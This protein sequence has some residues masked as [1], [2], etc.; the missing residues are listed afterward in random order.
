[1]AL[2]SCSTRCLELC[3]RDSLMRKLRVWINDVSSYENNLQLDAQRLLMADE[4]LVDFSDISLR[5]VR[6]QHRAG[7]RHT[8]KHGNS[9]RQHA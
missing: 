8:V 7:Q 2:H 5:D 6:P 9:P 4:R 1:M 3:S